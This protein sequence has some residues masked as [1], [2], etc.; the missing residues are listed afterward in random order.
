MT[1]QLSTAH[2]I[3]KQAKNGT[4][5]M[6]VTYKIYCLCYGIVYRN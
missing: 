5:V 3:G 2:A 1:E 6:S 4:I